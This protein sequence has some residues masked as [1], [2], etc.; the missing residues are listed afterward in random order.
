MTVFSSPNKKTALVYIFGTLFN[1]WLARRQLNSQICFCNHSVSTFCCVWIIGRKSGHIQ[2]CIWKRRNNNPLCNKGISQDPLSKYINSRT[3]FSLKSSSQAS[4]VSMR[5]KCRRPLH[6]LQH[7]AKHIPWNSGPVRG[8]VKG[9]LV[10][11]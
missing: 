8:S 2:M 5:K 4:S 11:I 6:P 3:Q 7:L 1:A 9:D 10:V